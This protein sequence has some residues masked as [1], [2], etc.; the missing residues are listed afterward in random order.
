MARAHRTFR[1]GGSHGRL[2]QWVAPPIQGSVAVAAGGA[3]ITSSFS[4]EEALTVIR[5]RGVLSI[6]PDSVQVD[7]EIIGAF[8]IGVVTAEAFAAGVVSLPEPFTDAD[9]GGWMV[10][11]SFA[12]VLKFESSAGIQVPVDR[13][14]EIDSKA[15]WKMSQNEVLVAVAE[16]A[17][18]LA[19]RVIDTAR[20]LVKLS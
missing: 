16:S 17:S 10:W 12:Y 18:G 1:S 8:G 13:V 5:T 7:G 11:Q 14:I 19:F 2:T 9:W 3:A 15:M 6:Q 4:V 20:I